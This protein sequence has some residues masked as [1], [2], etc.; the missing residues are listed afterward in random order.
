M[1]DPRPQAD[2]NPR[3][4][5]A[6]ARTLTD[7]N[8]PTSPPWSGSGPLQRQDMEA[9]VHDAYA[10]TFHVLNLNGTSWTAGRPNGQN[11]LKKADLFVRAEVFVKEKAPGRRVEYRRVIPSGNVVPLEASI[12]DE[13]RPGWAPSSTP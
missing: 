12:V 3:H 1:A 13:S 6:D 4:E 5:H 10:P 7:E 8:G 2:L 11:Q 9:F